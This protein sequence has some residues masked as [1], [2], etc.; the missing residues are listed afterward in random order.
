MGVLALAAC[1]PQKAAVDAKQSQAIANEELRIGYI[2][3]SK[4]AG[5]AV[6]WALHQGSLQK[7]VAPIGFGSVKEYVFANGP[8]LSEALLSNK[9]D[10]GIFGD[11]P[12]LTAQANRG[13]STLIGFN[14]VGH[15]VWLMGREGIETLADLEGKNVGVP[16]GSYMHRYVSGLISQGLLK[17]VTLNYLLPRDA[18][19]ALS[20][21]DIDAFA[22]PIQL[23]PQL[24]ALNYNTV[25]L[26]S[27]HGLEGNSVIVVTDEFLSRNPQFFKTFDSVRRQAVKELQAQPDAYYQYYLKYTD[28][29]EPIIRASFPM[30]TY[31]EDTF[32]EKGMALLAGT[33]SFL[34][35][36]K[37]V[38]KD[39]NV[40]K[41]L[42]NTN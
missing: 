34:L 16:N 3:P 41:W 13:G 28:Y 31:L 39:V 5:G 8:D 23:G 29:K 10:V 40:D 22:A 42:I 4:T 15:D 7:A 32:P 37:I 18:Q 38:Q 2:G 36:Q 1:Q 24:Q 12:A 14:A 26:A 9:L 17:N 35:Q 6:G 33:K 21:G 11:T 25:D 20:R 30:S 27:K 19:S